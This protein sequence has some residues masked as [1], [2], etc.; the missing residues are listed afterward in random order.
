MSNLVVITGRMIVPKT[1]RDAFFAIS[2]RQVELSR[3]ETGCVNYWLFE[4]TFE[5]GIFFFYEEWQDRAAVDLHFKQSYCL[6]FVKAL[7][8]LIT[9]EADMKIRTIAPKATKPDA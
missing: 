7:R 3:K 8:K 1:N 2:K 4:D 9:G 5:P 6:E